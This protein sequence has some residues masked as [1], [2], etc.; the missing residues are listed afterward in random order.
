MST[1]PVPALSDSEIY[2][3]I[4]S[5][6]L[7]H[8]LQPGTKLV[9]D[10]LGTAFGVSRTRIRPVLVRLAN[11]Q[12]VTLTPNRGACV[13]QPTEQEAREV[14]EARRL[15]E[16]LLLER[17]MAI[18]TPADIAVL[19]H[20][21]A[22]E[23]A[24][25]AK[26]DMRYAI[27]MSGDFH[28]MIAERAGQQTLGRILRE[29]VSRTSLILMTWGPVSQTDPNSWAGG[30]G[31]REHRSVLDAIRLRDVEAATRLMREHLAHLEAQVHFGAVATTSPDLIALFGQA[32]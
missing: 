20:F 19:A 12:I 14:F 32:A 30:C 8:R 22:E 2:E 21:I 7:D 10:K 29:L 15:V 18:A 13:A 28:L 17:F 25:R 11:E 1:A 27:R 9:E 24:A 4:V 26:G 6:I 31:C 3:R 16:P 23:E 5:A